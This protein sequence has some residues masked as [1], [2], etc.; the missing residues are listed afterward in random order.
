MAV[1]Q[2]GW[3][4][5]DRSV[6]KTYVVGQ[7]IRIALRDGDAGFLLKDIADWFDAN[8]KDIDPGIL[9]DWGYAERPI[10]GGVEL[11][12]HASGTAIDVNATKWPLGVEPSSYLTDDQIR[13]VRERLKLYEGTIRWGGD[14]TGRKDPMHFEINAGAAEV[15]RVAN[16]IRNS[17]KGGFLMALS[18]AEQAEALTRLRNIDVRTDWWL[19]PDVNPNPTSKGELGKHLRNLNEN[20]AATLVIVKALAS[21]DAAAIAAAIPADLAQQVVDLLGKKLQA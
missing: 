16:K 4:A 18:D 11:S 14:Y 10:R 12:N 15:A 7:G 19:V 13:R 9:D 21:K 17:T 5:N 1:S 8:I 2:N 3:L 20:A 6:I